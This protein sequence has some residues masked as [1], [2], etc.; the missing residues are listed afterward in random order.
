MPVTSLVF[1]VGCVAASA[2]PPSN[3]FASEWLVFQAIL[4]SPELPQWGLKILVPAVG[5]LLALSAALVA[6]SFVRA[7]GMTFLGR[8]RTPAAEKAA[9]V[10]RWALAGM[11]VPAGLCALAGILPGFAIDGFSA[12]VRMLIGERMPV[13]AEIPWLS[14]IPVAQSHS[15]YNGLLVF[16]FVAAAASLAAFSIHRLASREV[17]RAPLWGCGFPELTAA[18]Q[19]TAG[20]FAQPIV[21]VFGAVVFRAREQVEMPRPG[22]LGPARLTL[23]AHDLIWETLYAPVAGAVSFAAGQLNR[24]QFLTIRRY[25]TLVFCSLIFLLLALTLWP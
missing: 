12:A 1:L 3:G 9:E 18:M 19:Y 6:A 20:S 10:D 25:L 22:E 11:I 23:V 7:F 4:Q 21:R 17:R 8:A 14:V 13:Q 24:L 2:L 5:G 16:L 15:S